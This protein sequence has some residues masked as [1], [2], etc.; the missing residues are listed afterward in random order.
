MIKGLEL[1]LHEAIRRYP[2]LLPYLIDMGIDIMDTHYVVRFDDD[3]LVEIG[4]P[5]D[6]WLIAA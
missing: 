5:E 4:Y 2:R 1:P 6:N 3:G